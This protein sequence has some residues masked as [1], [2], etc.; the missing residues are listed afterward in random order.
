MKKAF[1]TLL[2]AM[3]ASISFIGCTEEEIKPRTSELAGGGQPAD[4]L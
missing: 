1:F 2:I 3:A 4:P